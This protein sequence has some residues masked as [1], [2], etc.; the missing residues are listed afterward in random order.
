MSS[1]THIEKKVQEFKSYFLRTQCII[2][3]FNKCCFGLN[4]R[5][6][7]HTGLIL[8]DYCQIYG[9]KR[10]KMVSIWKQRV[11]LATRSKDITP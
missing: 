8:K 2:Q 5:P 3:H 1:L 6:T 10:V 4:D 9:P 11:C 7:T